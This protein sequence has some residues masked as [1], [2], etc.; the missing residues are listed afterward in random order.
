MPT[1]AKPGIR[2]RLFDADESDRLIELDAL[3]D[4]NP[5]ERQLLWI[6]ATGE[7]DAQTSRRLAEH[8]DLQQHT[9]LDLQ[10]TDEEPSVALHRDYLHVRVAAEPDPRDARDTG[11]LDVIAAPNV[12]LSQH[13][14]PIEFLEDVDRRIK[15][16]AQS[17]TLSAPSE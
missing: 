17:G 5:T 4:V 15:A 10:R 3:F 8:F 12:V 2:A 11:W 9:A 14:R 6:D 7:V 1:D 16:D 13:D